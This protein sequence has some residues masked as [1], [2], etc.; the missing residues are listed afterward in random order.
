MSARLART[1]DGW[2]AVTPAGLVRLDLPAATTAG[3]L[4]DR[5]ALAAAIAAAHAAAAAAP[6]DA[7][8]ADSVDLLSPVTAPARVVAQA[9]NYRSHAA[10]SG[11]DPDTAPAAFFRKASHSITGPAG[12]S[13]ARTG[14][15]TP[16]SVNTSMLYAAT[17]AAQAAGLAAPVNP[18][19]SGER[20]AE[21]TRRTGSRVLV[22]AGL[23]DA[24]ATA[25]HEDGRL[26][27][28][29]TG[30]DP[31]RVRDA[32]AGFALTV[33]FGPSPALQTAAH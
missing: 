31:G 9:V 8:P 21:L 27:V 7:V 15:V 13:S 33:R 17:L 11:L 25:A 6:Q 18:A 29:V 4:A 28:T 14:S 24:R 30:A 20:I 19:L 12:E 16:P 3:L 32:V 23:P 26:I 2:W 5:A 10:D 22:A 1:A